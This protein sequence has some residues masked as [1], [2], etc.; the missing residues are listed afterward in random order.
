MF[1]QKDETFITKIT[2]YRL[3]FGLDTRCLVP[4]FDGAILSLEWKED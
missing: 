2:I 1:S 3:C 4:G